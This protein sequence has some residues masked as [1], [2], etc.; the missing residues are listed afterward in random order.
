MRIGASVSFDSIA[1]LDQRFSNVPFP[2]ELALP[3]KYFE[4]WMPMQHRMHEV[5]AFFQQQSALDILSIHAPHGYISEDNFLQWGKVTL[6]FA[7]ALGVKYVT[8]HPNK[9]RTNRII[10]QRKTMQW[11]EQLHSQYKARIS[12][13]TFMHHKRVFRPLELVEYDLPMTLDT[14]HI[15]NDKMVM[16]ILARYWKNIPVIHLSSRDGRKQHLPIDDFCRRVVDFL[17]GVAWKGNL[18]LEY[19]PEYH[20]QYEDDMDQVR[21]VIGPFFSNPL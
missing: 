13:E 15:H 14:S 11:L 7:D 20:E 5:Q 9:I 21:N 12:I 17:T 3:W 2:I 10:A 19:L 18:I 8:V 6:A 4:Y 16:Y 1:Q